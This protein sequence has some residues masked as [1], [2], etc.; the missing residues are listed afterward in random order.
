MDPHT[1]CESCR[2]ERRLWDAL[3]SHCGSGICLVRTGNE[4]AAMWSPESP[5]RLEEPPLDIESPCSIV[6]EKP[7]EGM[8]WVHSCR[9]SEGWQ[10]AVSHSLPQRISQGDVSIHGNTVG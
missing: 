4:G 7:G 10:L 9:G 8:A 6:A 3:Q 5:T 2:G 1:A